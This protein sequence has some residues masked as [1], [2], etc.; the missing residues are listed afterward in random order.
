MFSL[1]SVHSTELI[2]LDSW[3]TAEPRH[4]YEFF[5]EPQSFFRRKEYIVVGNPRAGV[6]D[7]RV[8]MAFRNEFEHFETLITKLK[9]LIHDA[10]WGV[11]VA[12]LLRFT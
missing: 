8:A 1:R 10:E 5:V 4:F 3:R 12:R 7:L 9:R 2:M 11:S 6:H